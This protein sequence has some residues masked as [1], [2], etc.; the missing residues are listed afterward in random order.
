MTA[1]KPAPQNRDDLLALKSRLALANPKF[2]VGGDVVEISF[3]DLNEC[4]LLVDDA[5]AGEA[6]APEELES[7]I[8]DRSA[9]RAADLILANYVVTRRSPTGAPKP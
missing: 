9:N 6:V 2:R 8:A 7:L 1:A 5:L 3:A 4:R